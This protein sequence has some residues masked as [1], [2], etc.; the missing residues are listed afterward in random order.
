MVQQ[1]FCLDFPKKSRSRLLGQK[2]STVPKKWSTGPK[3]N[4]RPQIGHLEH[5]RS[6]KKKRIQVS[7]E[8]RGT[9]FKRSPAPQKVIL[10]DPVRVH[11][12][13]IALRPRSIAIEICGCILPSLTTR[14]D[15]HL[16]LKDLSCSNKSSND[17]THHRNIV[18]HVQCLPAPTPTRIAALRTRDTP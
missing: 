15:H 5:T 14:F 4:H 16:I 13:P 10:V 7:F 8:E 17:A 11:R 18:T 1:A 6:G 3:V 12:V 2:W 9:P